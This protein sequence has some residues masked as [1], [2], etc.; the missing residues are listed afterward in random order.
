M[1]NSEDTPRAIEDLGAGI[2]DIVQRECDQMKPLINT[3]ENREAVTKAVTEFLM[4]HPRPALEVEDVSTPE[5][6]KAGLA[7]LRWVTR[8]LA[9]V[10]DADEEPPT[11]PGI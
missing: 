7:T 5:D 1:S 2:K 3:K 6:R 10:D 8:D 9:W 4:N 11:S